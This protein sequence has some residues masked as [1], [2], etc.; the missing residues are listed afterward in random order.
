MADEPVLY[1]ARRPKQKRCR[2]LHGA[3][4]ATLRVFKSHPLFDLMEET[5]DAPPVAIAREHLGRREREIGGVEKLRLAGAVSGL[6]F[7]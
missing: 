6:V 3:L 1:D 7:V 4:G 5:F 2:P